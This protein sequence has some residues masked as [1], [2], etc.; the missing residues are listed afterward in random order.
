M[1]RKVAGRQSAAM[2]RFRRVMLDHHL[3]LEEMAREHA[4]A[5]NNHVVTVLAYLAVLKG[6]KAIDPNQLKEHPARWQNLKAKQPPKDAGA[7]DFTWEPGR[8]FSVEEAAHCLP[9]SL[10]YAGQDCSE[11]GTGPRE[12]AVIRA[13]FADVIPMPAV[14]NDADQR[15]EDAGLRQAFEAAGQEV[16]RRQATGQAVNY[17]EI[18]HAYQHV[19]KPAALAAYAKAL[20]EIHP[21]WEAE[22]ARRRALEL[23]RHTGFDAKDLGRDP[24]ASFF[25]FQHEVLTRYAEVTRDRVPLDLQDAGLA[26]HVKELETAGKPPTERVWPRTLEL[27]P[28]GSTLGGS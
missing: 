23:K 17:A 3:G 28:P 9:C 20:Q 19:W 25:E 13:P 6:R 16:L 15:A 1:A 7:Y 26:T 18:R 27:L 14:Y 2:T 12:A 21:M 10:D 22:R 24:D 5:R 4:S 8:G 11:L